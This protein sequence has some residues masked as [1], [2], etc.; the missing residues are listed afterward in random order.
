MQEYAAERGLVL[1]MVGDRGRTVSTGELFTNTAA[2]GF[3]NKGSKCGLYTYT[4]IE[5][6]TNEES[7]CLY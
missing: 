2:A 6:A 1:C 4:M 3:C 7:K 5:S